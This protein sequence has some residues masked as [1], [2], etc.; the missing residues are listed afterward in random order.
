PESLAERIHALEYEH[1]PK[2]VDAYINKIL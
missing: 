2:V 1:F